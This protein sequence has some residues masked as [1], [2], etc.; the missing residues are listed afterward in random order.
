MPETILIT[1]PDCKKQ[2][3]GPAELAGKKIRCKACGYI[4]MVKAGP[5]A[6]SNREPQPAKATA[7]PAAKTKP[8][9]PA[10]GKAVEPAP[11]KPEPPPTKDPEEKEGKIAYQL[12]DAFIGHRCPQCAAELQ[13]DT[14]ICINCGYN[15]QTRS[16]TQTV[17]VIES[18]SRE[19]FWW[20]APG[21]L[22]VLGTLA[23]IGVICYLWIGLR[24]MED[25]W[26]VFPTKVYGSVV[27]AFCG[28]FAGRFALKRL[29][30][31]FHPPEKPL[32]P[33]T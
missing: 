29:L 28:W 32:R 16:R 10:K 4:F 11:P 15:T 1:C 6:R 18:T 20:L 17:M 19:W 24:G 3:K 8:S 5:A 27:A 7:A 13:E 12:T 30:R 25:T 22:C 31:D 33:E 23:A 9:P 26:W 2:L 14:V 21:F